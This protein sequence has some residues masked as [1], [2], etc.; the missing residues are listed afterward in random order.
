MVYKMVELPEGEEH[1][2][3]RAV[4]DS[5]VCYSIRSSH[6]HELWTSS[7]GFS[8]EHI[9]SMQVERDGIVF[10]STRKGLVFALETKIGEVL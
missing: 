4:D 8:Y 7:V 2:C 1:T 9:S 6:P 10:G 3:N 5:I